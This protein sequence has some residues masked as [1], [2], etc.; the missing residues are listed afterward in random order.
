MAKRLPDMQILP[1]LAFKEIVP[2][3]VKPFA[4]LIG[5]IIA[6]ALMV[7][8]GGPSPAAE[9]TLGQTLK[10]IFSTPTPTPRP[11]KK[12][13]AIAAK[14]KS[15]TPTPSPKKSSTPREKES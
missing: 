15:P 10:K 2:S 13:S 6:L 11:R 3:S 1:K 9:Q 5:I 4:M 14:K 8:V 12:K 7:A